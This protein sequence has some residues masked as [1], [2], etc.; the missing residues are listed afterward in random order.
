MKNGTED[1]Q[2]QEIRN[3]MFEQDPAL[4]KTQQQWVYYMMFSKA[5][6]VKTQ[7]GPNLNEEFQKRKTRVL[8]ENPPD[9]DEKYLFRFVIPTPAA[10]NKDA[11][12][13]RDS[14]ALGATVPAT[15]GGRELASDTCQRPDD[16][17][18]VER[19][20]GD[21]PPVV[22]DI[23][24]IAGG[25]ECFDGVEGGI[26]DRCVLGDA[27]TSPARTVYTKETQAAG[28]GHDKGRVGDSAGG[29]PSPR[30]SGSWAMTTGFEH[31]VP[32]GFFAEWSFARV[33]LEALHDG[34]FDGAEQ[35]FVHST[36]G[37]ELLWER[38]SGR[39][40]LGGEGVLCLS[41]ARFF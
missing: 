37:L 28:C 27:A 7:H 11:F 4:K 38:L 10:T 1:G 36:L 18:L 3:K 6:Y 30:W 15:T 16:D 32:D 9:F 24:R 34:I 19:I 31:Y 12:L 35:G 8:R 13:A 39:S 14:L 17:A 41:P 21:D 20:A 23:E 25:D 2:L 33:P 40:F 5:Y 26:G 29:W 22:K